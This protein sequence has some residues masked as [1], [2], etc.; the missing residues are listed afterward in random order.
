MPPTTPQKK[1]RTCWSVSMRSSRLVSAHRDQARRNFSELDSARLAPNGYFQLSLF[2]CST[3]LVSRT[4]YDDA[5][6]N[7]LTPTKSGR[8]DY[9]PCLEVH[10]NPGLNSCLISASRVPQRAVWISSRFGTLHASLTCPRAEQPSNLPSFTQ[11]QTHHS[12][13]ASSRTIRAACHSHSFTIPGLR[14]PLNKV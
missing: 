5:R 12:F 13:R 9:L 7:A 6:K 14:F 10:P 3:T 8:V 4:K 1:E 11:R 2:G